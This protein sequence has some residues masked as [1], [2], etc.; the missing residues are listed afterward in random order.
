MK[1]VIISSFWDLKTGGGT[2]VVVR[3]LA[4]GLQ[5]LGHKVVVITTHRHNKTTADHEN[6]LTVYRLFPKNLYWIR[7]KHEQPIT[8]RIVWHLIDIWNPHAYLQVRKILSREKPDIVHTHK[9]QGM[10]PSTWAAANQTSVK[11]IIHTSHDYELFS[12]EGTRQPKIDQWAKNRPV[13]V[14]LLQSIAAS[15]SKKVDI[16]T[17]PSQYV[18]DLHSKRGLFAD[19]YRQVVPNPHGSTLQ[20]IQQRQANDGASSNKDTIRYLYM[21]RFDPS[22]GVDLLC[23]AFQV[24]TKTYPNIRL[25][26]LGSGE[27]LNNLQK[28]YSEIPQIEFHGYKSGEEKEKFL[29]NCDALVVPS[30]WQ[31][32]FGIVIPEAFSYGKAVIATSVGGIPE[33]V[34]DGETGILI[35]PGDVEVLAQTISRVARSPEKIR[36][37]TTACYESSQS[38]TLDQILE[39]Y[40]FLYKMP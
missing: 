27:M 37:M 29:A 18:L 12:P 36:R 20:E 31:E 8:K 35:P 3:G 16:F 7:D 40:E 19:A 25:D 38:F 9:L 24:C 10:S 23:E 22:K 32:P 2:A 11:K 33:V 28:Q 6:G 15:A 1:I 14:R 5:S 34:K 39:N 26:L 30:V 13:P 21:G 4:Y 17:S